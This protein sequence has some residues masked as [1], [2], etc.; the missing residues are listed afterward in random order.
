MEAWIEL[1]ELLA[2]PAFRARVRGMAEAHSAARHAGDDV[3]AG[4][5]D[6][7]ETVVLA[8]AGAALAAGVD[9]AS[10]DAADLLVP[11]VDAVRG[12]RPDTTELRAETADR[13]ATGTD[14]RVERYW[15][16]MGVINGWPPFP[17]LTPAFSWTIDALRAHPR[18][19]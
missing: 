6:G 3:M 8:S 12:D 19:T 17:A 13:F 18:R 7:L 11:I 10:S 5:T 9:P 15:Q 2:D 4:H 14:T 16:L 1:A